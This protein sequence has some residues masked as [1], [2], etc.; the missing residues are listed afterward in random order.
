MDWIVFSLSHVFDACPHHSNYTSSF[1]SLLPINV[2]FW[3]GLFVIQYHCLLVIWCEKSSDVSWYGCV[4]DVVFRFLSS[5]I[6]RISIYLLFNAH[7]WLASV[8]FYVKYT[9]STLFHQCRLLQ[10]HWPKVQDP[11]KCTLKRTSKFQFHPS[12]DFWFSLS[13]YNLQFHFN[14]K[15]LHL[16]QFINTVAIT[17]IL[18]T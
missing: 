18:L 17:W 7:S 6:F 13:I 14:S 16:I 9:V 5:L 15:T 2:T 11:H 3:L 10:I 1:P 12:N 4:V 8:N